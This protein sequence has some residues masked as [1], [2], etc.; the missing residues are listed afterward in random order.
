VDTKDLF[1]FQTTLKEMEIQVAA[2]KERISQVHSEDVNGRVEDLT[3]REQLYRDKINERHK[4]DSVSVSLNTVIGPALIK[5]CIDGVR[6]ELIAV[7][8]Y[9]PREN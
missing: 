1:G 6:V 5:F 3:R 4:R 9:I 2:V 8:A 7:G